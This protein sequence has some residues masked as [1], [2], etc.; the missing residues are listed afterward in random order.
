MPNTI[1]IKQDTT[2]I[3]ITKFIIWVNIFMSTIFLLLGLY[4][5]FIQP[6]NNEN[7]NNKNKSD[8]VVLGS[9]IALFSGLS[10]CF[11][12]FLL[13][14][15]VHYDIVK[16]FVWLSL[17]SYFFTPNSIQIVADDNKKNKRNKRNKN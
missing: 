14:K 4:F 2:F 17:F 9:W 16:V 7:N 13:L 6:I 12:Y 15:Y 1:S 5:I 10:I 3:T 11:N 8:N